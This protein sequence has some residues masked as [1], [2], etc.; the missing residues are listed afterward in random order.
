MSK[1]IAEVGQYVTVKQRGKSVFLPSE[2]S[3][4]ITSKRADSGVMLIE[5][6]SRDQRF[7]K[8]IF[9]GDDNLSIGGLRE[10]RLVGPLA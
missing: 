4:E 3:G 10:W 9:A 8:K 7:G 1:M 2:Y 5:V 6:T